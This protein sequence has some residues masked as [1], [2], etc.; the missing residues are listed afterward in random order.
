MVLRHA[1]TVLLPAV[2]VLVTGCTPGPPKAPHTAKPQSP[3]DPATASPSVGPGSPSARPAW[4]ALPDPG[5]APSGVALG[6]N[7]ST[8][9]STGGTGTAPVDLGTLPTGTTHLVLRLVCVGPGDGDVLDGHEELLYR[10]PCDS[11]PAGAD[12]SGDLTG[13]ATRALT[14]LAVRMLPTTA[15]RLYIGA[16]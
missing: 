7:G 2:V 9:L 16:Y 1:G 15:W 13:L 3:T 10:V 8:L 14:G 12:S 6:P 4:E 5:Q 11:T